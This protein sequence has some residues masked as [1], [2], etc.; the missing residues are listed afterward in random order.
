[1][2]Q[3]EEPSKTK[4]ASRP[5]N[6]FK[7]LQG[8]KFPGQKQDPRDP[9]QN[10]KC[11]HGKGNPE[12]RRDDPRSKTKPTLD[13]KTSRR[14]KEERPQGEK[15]HAQKETKETQVETANK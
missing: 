7:A 11:E 13:V 3:R 6:G 8:T 1:M 15:Q 9:N 2:Q 10:T 4:R 14:Q 5:E 12:R